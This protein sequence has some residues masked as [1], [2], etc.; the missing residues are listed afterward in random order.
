[1][2][3]SRLPNTTHGLRPRGLALVVFFPSLI[4]PKKEKEIHQGR[5]RIDIVMNNGARGG[6]FANLHQVRK[7]PSA[8]V[9][10]ECKN[11]TTEVVNPELDQLS[12]RFAVNRGK[13]GFLCCRTFEDR[14]VFVERCRDTLRDDRGLILPLDDA[15]VL[16]LLGEIG[17]GRRSDLNDRLTQL[18]D[19]VWLS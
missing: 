17:S 1:M 10:F 6:I 12:G 13:V 4:Y 7:L 19:E 18:V 9:C 11:Y 16:A 2:H 8:F 15:A 14:A 5:K 3:P